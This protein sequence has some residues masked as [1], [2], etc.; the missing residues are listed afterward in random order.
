[1]YPSRF[2]YGI[3]NGLGA[4]GNC[5]QGADIRIFQVNS[6]AT[7]RATTATRAILQAGLVLV[8]QVQVLMRLYPLGV[9]VTYAEMGWKRRGYGKNTDKRRDWQKTKGV[10]QA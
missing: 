4:A 10:P 5:P 7:K 2:I 6:E 8:K 1:M 9:P 3:Y